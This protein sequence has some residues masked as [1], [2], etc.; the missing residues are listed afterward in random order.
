MVVVSVKR[1]TKRASKPT[2]Q[3][4]IRFTRTATATA[5]VTC[6]SDNNFDTLIYYTIR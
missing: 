4:R 2:R 6:T 5:P 3:T 1:E